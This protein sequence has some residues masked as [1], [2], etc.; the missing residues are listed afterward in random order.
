MFCI[1]TQKTKPVPTAMIYSFLYKAYTQVIIANKAIAMYVY[2]HFLEIFI[3]L[4][5]AEWW[6]M[7]PIELCSN[8][9]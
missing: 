8:H 3:V 4:K 5:N 7:L 1:C 2:N 6:L 9:H